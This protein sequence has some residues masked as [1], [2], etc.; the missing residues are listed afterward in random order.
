MS[1]F[2]FSQNKQK[3]RALDIC[4]WISKN[5]I[6]MSS[7]KYTFLMQLRI[8]KCKW[9]NSSQKMTL[10]LVLGSMTSMLSTAKNHNCRPQLRGG[11]VCQ[12]PLHLVLQTWDSWKSSP[13]A[14]VCCLFLLGSEPYHFINKTDRLYTFNTINLGYTK[15]IYRASLSAKWMCIDA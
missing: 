2:C 5:G 14:W 9:Y 3:I 15:Y 7:L 4:I 13:S 10:C 1:L 12:S 8:L 6:Q 11:S